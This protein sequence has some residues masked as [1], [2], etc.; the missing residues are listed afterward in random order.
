MKID[1]KGSFPGQTCRSQLRHD[2]KQYWSMRKTAYLK[3][4]II[5]W[6]IVFSDIVLCSQFSTSCKNDSPR[7]IILLTAWDKKASNNVW[8][9]WE[10]LPRIRCI[11]AVLNANWM[12]KPV[13]GRSSLWRRCGTTTQPSLLFPRPP[14][15]YCCFCLQQWKKHLH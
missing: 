9:S 11:L 14:W 13:I 12:S 1:I 5:L 2:L 4:V 7:Q 3:P 15:G 10:N 6:E 8:Q